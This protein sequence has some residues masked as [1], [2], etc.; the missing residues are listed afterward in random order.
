MN[1][2]LPNIGPVV[3][4]GAGPTPSRCPD[5]VR[6]T[7]GDLSPVGDSAAETPVSGRE[8]F[9]KACQVLSAAFFPDGSAP[10]PSMPQVLWALRV[11]FQLV[12]MFFGIPTNIQMLG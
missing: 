7:D 12:L 6:E 3:I 8:L 1:A 2:R 4:P 5:Q 9:N 11:Y 10:Q